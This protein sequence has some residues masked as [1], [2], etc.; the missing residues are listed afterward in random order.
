MIISSIRSKRVGGIEPALRPQPKGQE[1]TAGKPAGIDAVVSMRPL[2]RPPVSS[3]PPRR[4]ARSIALCDGRVVQVRPVQEGDATKLLDMYAALSPESRYR[5]YFTAGGL[6][7]RCDA[8]RLAAAADAGDVVLVAV[9]EDYPEQIAGVAQLAG[10]EAAL[11]VRDDYQSIGLGSLLLDSLLAAARRRGLRRVE[12]LTLAGNSRV[13]HI[14]HRRQAVI[15]GQADGVLHATIST[16]SRPG[17]RRRCP[18]RTTP[19]PVTR[20]PADRGVPV[21]R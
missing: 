15:D 7:S 14:L 4:P 3:G 16:E 5:R 10:T 19:G 8:E 18:P 17:P 13:L 2:S 9:S 12:A 20:Q 21:Q 1:S 11:T 6:K